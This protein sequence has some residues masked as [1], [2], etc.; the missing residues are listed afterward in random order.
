[1]HQFIYHYLNKETTQEIKYILSKVIDDDSY[2]FSEKEKMQ[3]INLE[4]GTHVYYEEDEYSQSIWWESQN[5]F[6]A[7]FVYYINGNQN[8]LGE[9]KLTRSELI[10]LVKQVQ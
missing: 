3:P 10:D 2:V 4:N 6:L 5:G 9:Y 1:M 8:P 7:R